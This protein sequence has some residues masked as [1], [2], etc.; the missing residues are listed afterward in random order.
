MPSRPA[1][2]F[3]SNID[4]NSTGHHH[5][6]QIK[7]SSSGIGGVDPFVLS[8]RL[9][10]GERIPNRWQGNRQ[11]GA[12]RKKSRIIDRDGTGAGEK[13]H[14]RRNGLSLRVQGVRPEGTDQAC[15]FRTRGYSPA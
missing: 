8:R 9:L 1:C 14:R 6:S 13:L 7:G 3:E 5:P 11:C 2:G 15:E 4:T 10:C 12:Q